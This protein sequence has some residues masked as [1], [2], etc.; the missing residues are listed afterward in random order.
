MVHQRTGISGPDYLEVAQA[1]SLQSLSLSG[2]TGGQ[3]REPKEW[4]L[5]IL[6]AVVRNC[7]GTARIQFSIPTDHQSLNCNTC[8]YQ[9]LATT[10]DTSTPARRRSSQG[11][12]TRRIAWFIE[13]FS[14]DGFFS[15]SPLQSLSPS[16]IAPLLSTN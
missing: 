9:I 12:V 6:G 2:I 10:L 11:V 15:R 5:G 3:K 1:P 7:T 16:P 14:K 4:V 8:D 13:G